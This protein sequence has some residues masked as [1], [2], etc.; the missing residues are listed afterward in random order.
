M[1][2]SYGL[3]SIKVMGGDSVVGEATGYWLDGPGIER[4]W[5]GGEIFRAHPDR[6]V[7][8]TQPPT[9]LV[10]GYSRG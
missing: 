9:K 4:R 10:L 2:G 1:L 6:P 7:G 3:F 5:G 8:P